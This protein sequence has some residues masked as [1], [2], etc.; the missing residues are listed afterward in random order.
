MA[1]Y[2]LATCTPELLNPFFPAAV[3][4]LVFG[5]VTGLV[6]LLFVLLLPR[7][8]PLSYSADG[9]R[10]MKRAVLAIGSIGLL[11]CALQLVLAAWSAW[12]GISYVP[13]CAIT[14]DAVNDAQYHRS[15]VAIDVFGITA[16]ASLGFTM[17]SGIATLILAAYARIRWPG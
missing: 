11:V 3:S 13:P 10:F 15:L 12:Q 17:A 4:A 9:L 2:S 6:G 1:I 8:L 5:L 14:S 16:F 7:L